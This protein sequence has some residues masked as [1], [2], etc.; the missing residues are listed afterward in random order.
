MKNKIFFLISGIL[1]PMFIAAGN[2]S[3]QTADSGIAAQFIMLNDQGKYTEAAKLM[4]PS[5]LEMVTPG[6]LEKIWYY[7]VKP[8][9]GF[10]KVVSVRE[11]QQGKFYAVFPTCRFDKADVTFAFAFDD[12]HQI[13][14]FHVDTVTP[15]TNAE[16]APKAVY[17]P[18][19][20]T[21]E[22]SQKHN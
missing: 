16:P 19:G 22:D 9:G 8:Q 14:G 5:F 6:N 17:H 11:M 15:Q 21:T 7:H 2:C 1:L 12:N 10:H 18:S 13:A 20:N 4:S 3:A